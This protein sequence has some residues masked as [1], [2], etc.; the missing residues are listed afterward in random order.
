M[1]PAIER[2]PGFTHRVAHP[3]A[4][5]VNRKRS[6]GAIA[7]RSQRRDKETAEACCFRTQVFFGPRSLSRAAIGRAMEVWSIAG[8]VRI[9]TEPWTRKNCSPNDGS[10]DHSS[11]SSP[12]RHP[13]HA[14][15][16]KGTAYPRL[17]G[18]DAD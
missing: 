16:R 10:A 6:S 18:L 3:S 8:W 12:S 1:P 17:G 15:R 5:S 4:E 14:D 11:A 2:K 7:R 13:R 9:V